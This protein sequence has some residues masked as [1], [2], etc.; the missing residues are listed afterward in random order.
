MVLRHF[1]CGLMFVIATLA[2][3]NGVC[4]EASEAK[5]VDGSSGQVLHGQ[6]LTTGAISPL[7]Y[8][9]PGLVL[10]MNRNTPPGLGTSLEVRQRMKGKNSLIAVHCL[11]L[12]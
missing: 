6:V 4:L 9:L 11:L 3:G 8:R 12:V 7:Q 2:G 5:E 10:P 1:I